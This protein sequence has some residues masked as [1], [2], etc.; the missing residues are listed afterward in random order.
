MEEKLRI[1]EKLENYWRILQTNLDWIKSSDQKATISFVSLYS[2]FR[3]LTP[4][5][6][7]NFRPSIIFFGSIIEQYPNDESYLKAIRAKMGKGDLIH[8]FPCRGFSVI[9]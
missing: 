7:K 1:D 6:F 3:C 2:A 8:Q 9:I 5:I 4:R